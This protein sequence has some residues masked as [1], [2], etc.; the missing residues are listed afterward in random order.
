MLRAARAF[1]VD[2]S[3]STATVRAVTL[4]VSSRGF[5]ALLRAPARVGYEVK[6]TL[7]LP[8]K[9]RLRVSA[10][11]AEVQQLAGNAR[12]SFAFV[13]LDTSDVEWLEVIVFDA[14]LEQLRGA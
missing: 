14:L 3:S 2:V 12:V 11:V 10:R 4:Q 6:A 8:G 5:G 13:D 9:E 7:S 1:Q